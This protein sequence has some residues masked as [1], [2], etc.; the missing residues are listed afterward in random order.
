[1]EMVLRSSSI[2][3]PAEIGSMGT[4]GAATCGGG[5]LVCEDAV[6]AGVGVG[7]GRH[8]VEATTKTPANKGRG[9]NLEVRTRRI[10]RTSFRFATGSDAFFGPEVQSFGMNRG[11]QSVYPAWRRYLLQGASSR[12]NSSFNFGT[13]PYAKTLVSRHRMHS[14]S[15]QLYAGRPVRFA[16]CNPSARGRRRRAEHERGIQCRPFWS[17]WNHCR[18]QDAGADDAFQSID[19]VPGR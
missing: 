3:A 7:E 19:E 4:R 8:A 2:L 5:E 9:R 16:K 10:L 11:Q 15:W 6:A 13:P 12:Y 1:M 14:S 17:K 18:S